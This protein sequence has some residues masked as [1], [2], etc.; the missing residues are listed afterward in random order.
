MCDTE[1][2]DTVRTVY[3]LREA[4]VNHGRAL[5]AADLIP[6]PT[7]R[8]RVLDTKMELEERTI[9]AIDVCTDEDEQA[10]A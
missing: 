5:A 2:S 8:D 10:V 6:S 4:A 3:E 9:A 7:T 1:A